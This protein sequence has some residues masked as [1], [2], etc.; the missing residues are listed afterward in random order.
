MSTR[1]RRSTPEALI[2]ALEE[3]G[4]ILES[5]AQTNRNLFI[6]FNFVLI[7]ALVL[8]LSVTDEDLL[9]GL[10]TIK[11]PL[12]NI[13][14]P[15]WAF[16]SI[17]PLVIVALHFDLL[18]N[19]GE[20]RDK[21]AAWSRCWF[22][23]HPS[24]S[25]NADMPRQ[26]YPFLFD[27][28][29]L[30]ANYTGSTAM[31]ARLLPG[32]CWLLYC[33]AAYTVLVIFFI[34]FADLQHYIYTGWHLL[35]LMFDAL[36]LYWY[37][38]GFSKNAKPV[39]WKTWLAIVMAPLWL[40]PY[41]GRKALG[42]QKLVRAQLL[43]LWLSNMAALWTLVLFT[44]IQAHIDYG[45]SSTFIKQALVWE[46]KSRSAWGLNIVPRLS[47]AGF[48]LTLPYKFF[49]LD[50]LQHP[51]KND[52]EL[53]QETR[54]ALDLSKRRL[55]F[56]DFSLALLP[57][58]NLSNARLQ[59]ADLWFASLQGADLDDAQLQ[60]ANLEFAQLQGSD[61]GSASLQGVFL[62]F[63]ELQGA[64][65]RNAQLQSSD[66]GSAQL[67]GA[68]LMSTQL[69]GS[70]LGSAQLQGAFLLFAQLQGADLRDAQLQ[71]ALLIKTQ[72]KGVALSDTK[73]LEYSWKE[74]LDWKQ[75][76]DFKPLKYESWAQPQEVQQRLEEAQKRVTAFKPEQLPP[77]VDK[78]TFATRWLGLLCQDAYVT[79]E[80]LDQLPYGKHPITKTQARQYLDS[81]KE[82]APYRT[83]LTD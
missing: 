48:R 82:C 52:S 77:P 39:A 41:A 34:R 64:N 3:A 12:L 49:E 62:I 7:T 58:S 35:L 57:H 30:H 68:F 10:S 43:L 50:H 55:A 29:C 27:F 36:I 33:W 54:N 75:G 11:L 22:K 17:A 9:I 80:M 47:L 23:V 70:N 76:Y 26:L 81:H 63:A 45:T 14:L 56:A 71:G 40:T 38:P 51:G 73:Q 59:G 21:L 69:Q 15:I 13:N 61:L 6:A 24:P 20:H 37:W 18:Q 66:L 4:K 25:R 8:C 65:L 67:Q 60:G 32:L 72:L 5:S 42:R 53:W 74:Q 16:A 46:E 83:L 44:L 19:L 79:K 1:N 31:R 28:A 2:K 78:E